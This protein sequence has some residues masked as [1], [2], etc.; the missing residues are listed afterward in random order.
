MPLT[1]CSSAGKLVKTACSQVKRG[2]RQSA[3]GRAGRA[4][5]AGVQEAASLPVPR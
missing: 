3:G 1:N 2:P 4:L 5:G